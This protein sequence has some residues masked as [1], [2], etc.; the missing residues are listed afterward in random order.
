MWLLTHFSNW[1]YD[2]DRF[3]LWKIWSNIFFTLK[4]KILKN[5]LTLTMKQINVKK[6]TFFCKILLLYGNWSRLKMLGIFKTNFKTFFTFN[7]FGH[8]KLLLWC[9]ATYLTISYIIWKTLTTSWGR[10]VPSSLQ[11][12]LSLSCCLLI[13]CLAWFGT[14]PV[15]RWCR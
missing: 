6:L 8:R 12:Q 2:Y 5:F 9:T 11:T 14:I 7:V 13:C 15:S 10:A 3:S 4:K 1:I